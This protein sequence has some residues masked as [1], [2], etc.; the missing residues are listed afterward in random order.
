MVGR[1]QHKLL[2]RQKEIE[3]DI[4][5]LAKTSLTKGLVTQIQ[6]AFYTKLKILN[7]SLW[8]LINNN[9]QNRHC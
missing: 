2:E 4:V 8:D 6:E 3:G 1:Q 9:N 7:W 5:L